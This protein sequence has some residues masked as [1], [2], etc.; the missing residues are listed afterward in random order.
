MTE[1]SCGGDSAPG[2]Y[3]GVY[4][5]YRNETIVSGVRPGGCGGRITSDMAIFQ[6]SK[7]SLII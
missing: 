5:V 3:N 2:V 6:C 1:V 7:S 4:N